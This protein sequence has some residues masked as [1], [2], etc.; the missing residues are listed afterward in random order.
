LL[1]GLANCLLHDTIFEIVKGLKEI[2]DVTE[3]H[4]FQMRLHLKEKHRGNDSTRTL[5][6]IQFNE[7]ECASVV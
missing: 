7:E 5:G 1:S 2:Q 3:K 4:L 6:S